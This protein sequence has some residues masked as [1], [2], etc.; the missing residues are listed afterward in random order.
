MKLLA[1]SIS[2][3]FSIPTSQNWQKEKVVDFQLPCNEFSSRELVKVT[4]IK[5]VQLSILIAKK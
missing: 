3:A 5:F 1:H 2:K 4:I